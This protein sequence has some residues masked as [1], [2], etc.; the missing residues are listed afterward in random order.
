MPRAIRRLIS[1][2]EVRDFL[3]MDRSLCGW[4]YHADNRVLEEEEVENDD[5]GVDQIRNDSIVVS[6]RFPSY[7]TGNFG[8]CSFIISTPCTTEGGFLGQRG[9]QL[10]QET[11]RVRTSV[12][13]AVID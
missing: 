9:S 10:H 6:F 3:T 13:G 12:V 5:A 4:R 1:P 7:H 11:F 8:A 2:S